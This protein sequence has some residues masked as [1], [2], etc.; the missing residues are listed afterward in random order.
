[1][2]PRSSDRLNVPFEASDFP[3]G[4]PPMLQTAA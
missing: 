2:A 3:K 4:S 1:M